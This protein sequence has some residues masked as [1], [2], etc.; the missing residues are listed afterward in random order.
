[1]LEVLSGHSIAQEMNRVKQE[2]WAE[3]VLPAVTAHDEDLG[4]TDQV[5]VATPTHLDPTQLDPILKAHGATRRTP[6]PWQAGWLVH[7]P[8]A[9]L[10]TLLALCMQ[11][12]THPGVACAHRSVELRGRLFLF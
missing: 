6:L 1:M 12:R 4:L 7:L 8:N 11:L 5:L 10:N 3:K 2:R 9:R